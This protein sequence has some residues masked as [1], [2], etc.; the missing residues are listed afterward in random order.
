SSLRP[1][2]RSWRNATSCSGVRW[3]RSSGNGTGFAATSAQKKRSLG[4]TYYFLI[5]LILQGTF[6]VVAA[7]QILDTL[8]LNKPCHHT[9]RGLDSCATIAFALYFVA[10]FS[11]PRLAWPLLPRSP[12]RPMTGSGTSP[13]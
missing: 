13:S 12:R 1:G 10:P 9:Y 4:G 11:S 7:Q 8:S 3:R 2:R 5:R 6:R